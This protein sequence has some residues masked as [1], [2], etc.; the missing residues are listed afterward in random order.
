MYFFLA[1]VKDQMGGVFVFFLA[2]VVAT[3]TKM[4]LLASQMG[5]LLITYLIYG[6]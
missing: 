2:T 3:L 4:G 6:G 1:K 5:M